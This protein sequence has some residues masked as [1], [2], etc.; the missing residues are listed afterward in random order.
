M[1]TMSTMRVN[2]RVI[3]KKIVIVL[4]EVGQKINLVD[5]GNKVPKTSFYNRLL[6][7]GDLVL[8]KNKKPARDT[9]KTTNKRTGLKTENRS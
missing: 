9:E 2:P 6:R 1:S 5:Q 4:D 3:D 7:D 8:V